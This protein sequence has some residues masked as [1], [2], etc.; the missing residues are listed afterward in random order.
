MELKEIIV[1]YEGNT[2]F[3]CGREMRKGW[4]GYFEPTVTPKRLYCKPC[5]MAIQSKEASKEI[6]ENKQEIEQLPVN[7]LLGDLRLQYDMLSVLQKTLDRIEGSVNTIVL[8]I[9]AKQAD[10]K[11]NKKTK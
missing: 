3:N 1:H 2:C 5:G 11:S 9:S 7:E 4:V 6:A 8:A 10:T